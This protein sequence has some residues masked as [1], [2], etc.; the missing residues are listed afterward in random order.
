MRLSFLTGFLLFS[1]FCTSQ[2]TYQ[3]LILDESLTENANAVVRVDKRFI[4]IR[5]VDEMII[6]NKRVVTVLNKSGKKHVNAQEWYDGKRKIKNI[7][8]V[9]YDSFGKEIYNIKEKDF[10]DVST[11]DGGTLY[12]DSR[13]KYLS[14]TPAQYPYTI[15]FESEIIT[16]NTVH[17]PSWYF[18]SDFNQS[19]QLSEFSVQFDPSV[20]ILT[21][22]CNFTD[23]IKNQSR[24]GLIKYTAEN[25]SA[26][27]SESIIPEFS[28]LVPVLK[29]APKNFN[30][31][32]YL[33]STN[34]W[35]EMG[36][37]MY[38]NLLA[39]RIDLPESTQRFIKELVKGVEDPISKA[40]I[41]YQ[42]VQDN[43][44]YISVQ[45]GIG[46]IQ[47]ISASEVDKVKYGDCK[48]LTNYTKALLDVVGVK[49]N[50][51]RVYASRKRQK[52]MDRNFPTFLG[53]SNHVILQVPI[54]NNDPIWLECTSQVQPFG[55]LGDFTDNRDVFVV[56]PEGGRIVK[57]P[58]YKNEQNFQRT[59]A[60]C[61][62]DINGG[63]TAD[64]RIKVKGIQYDNRFYIES[65][66]SEK[67][68]ERYKKYWSNINNIKI[69]SSNFENNK[70]DLV[71]D[72]KITIKA[73][74]Y[75]SKSGNR[76]FFAPN[77]LNRNEY[78][79]KRYR[80]RKFPFEIMRGFLDE[81]EFNI[82]IP[83]E[84]KVESLP[85]N[86]TVKTEFG[87]Y[88]ISIEKVDDNS[89]RYKRTLLVK[90]GLYPKEQYNSY[91]NF[92]K[93][94]TRNDAVQIV[95]TKK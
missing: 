48:G 64:I 28:S 54:E 85:E 93:E 20:G 63:I 39:D 10:K 45:E 18:I 76:I 75:G 72:E 24:E 15:E 2:N 49:S 95:L 84:Y 11:V 70:E 17:I 60:N 68:V 56:T 66:T 32:G 73:T 1:F 67:N 59:S 50:Y 37:W 4:E 23:V 52:G 62:L 29:I 77:I 90:K 7:S 94:V 47:P 78:V 8:A 9:I 13:L 21:K 19:I 86:K 71:F 3:A 91:R 31:E 83:N 26:I 33:G 6:K 43:T 69:I 41:I 53:Q 14:Y 40:K 61:S 92:R 74:N 27:S 5:S 36:K 51:T 55:F 38:E 65:L 80:N 58:S 79:P 22:E 44:R 82:R 46:G 87:N 57:T 81:D 89:L 12:S 30:Y 42:Y 35:E 88:Q 25:L 16:S 34:S